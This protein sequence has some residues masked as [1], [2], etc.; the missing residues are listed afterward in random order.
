MGPFTFRTQLFIF[1][2][3]CLSLELTHWE[4][5][6]TCF[7]HTGL[8][9][10]SGRLAAD[11]MSEVLWAKRWGETSAVSA[12]GCLG[13][14]RGPGAGRVP[15]GSS[16]PMLSAG[17][18]LYQRFISLL[19]GRVD[20]RSSTNGP[21][22]VETLLPSNPENHQPALD[23]ETLLLEEELEDIP[24]PRPL[25]ETEE[26]IELQ[27]VMV[28]ESPPAPE[29][30]LQTPALA[31]SVSQNQNEVSSSLKSLEQEYA[32]RYFVKDTSNEG[33][34]RLY[35]EFE[36]MI[37]DKNWKSLMR[38]I[39]LEEKDIETCKHENP[40][41][42]MEQHHKMLLRWRNKLGREASVFKLL[43]ALHKMQLH[44]CLE[45]IINVLLV[46]GILG[47]HGETSD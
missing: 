2:L 32:K 27:D 40:D 38:L 37:L 4:L 3:L 15:R 47:R 28:R 41:N 6:A 35:Y 17:M 14:G 5:P 29:Q 1:L 9:P 43:A 7:W 30:V 8:K 12:W 22:Q 16:P 31:A 34:T 20:E 46:E 44:M 39:G 23:I 26:G 21:L 13:G 11:A 10:R 33:T 36:E 42:L 19:K 25:E 24:C 18:W 45:N